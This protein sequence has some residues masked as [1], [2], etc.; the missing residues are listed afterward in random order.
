MRFG[1]RLRIAFASCSLVLAG[2]T[3]VSETKGPEVSPA[4]QLD[5]ARFRALYAEAET[6][7]EKANS[8]GVA[9]PDT[10]KL[11]ETAKE[12]ARR[13]DYETAIR[14]AEQ[15]RKQGELACQRG[16]VPHKTWRP[17]VPEPRPPARENP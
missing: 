11:L 1:R 2:C 3:T 9:W 14:R 13:G 7:R 12:A 4:L 10:A 15:A 6:A 8:L 5:Q 16:M 17:S